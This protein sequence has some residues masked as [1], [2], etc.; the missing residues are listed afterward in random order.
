MSEPKDFV[1][2]KLTRQSLLYCAKIG[3]MR[4]IQAIADRYGIDEAR[5]GW[6]SNIDGVTGEFVVSKWLHIEFEEK[7][8]VVGPGDVGAL[9]VRS[10]PWKEGRLLLHSPSKD[11]RESIYVLV[12][13]FNMP[14][15]YIA[16]W[17]YGK[18]GQLKENWRDDIHLARRYSQRP[19]YWVEQEALRTPASL[20]ELLRKE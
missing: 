9:E 1:E 16:G 2:I 3:V 7:I 15:Y 12:L 5:N 4:H 6:Q 13:L 14:T 11:N 18:E 19:C 17:C 10:T 8:G 20:L